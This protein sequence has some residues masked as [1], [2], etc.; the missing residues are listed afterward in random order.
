M[1]ITSIY[2][3][4]S[5]EVGEKIT[6]DI[7]ASNHLLR[8]LRLSLG[9]K[10]NLFNNENFEYEATIVEANKK[11]AEV[12]VDKKYL[13]RTESPLNITLAQ[14]ISRSEKMDYTIQKATELGVNSIVPIFSEYCEVALDGERLEKRI[15]HWQKI[16]ISA[17]E[18]SGRCKIPK[19]LPAQ[20]LNLFIPQKSDLNLV[21]DPRALISLPKF[22]NTYSISF[23]KITLLVGPEGGLSD[24]E[25]ELAKN[26]GFHS[27]TL[28][29]RILRT[30]TAGL[31]AISVLQAMLGDLK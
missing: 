20:R 29:P 22:I 9:S 7:L 10:I 14:A 3:D 11:L 5:L 31:V 2:F 23:N 4:G 1:R 21:L 27:V 12:L 15:E 13:V 8:V 19:I 25:I 30:E 17:S 28:G 24:Q 6:L 18:Q 26:N 16:A